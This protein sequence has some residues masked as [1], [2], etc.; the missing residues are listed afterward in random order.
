MTGTA[1]TEA[2]EFNEI[3][4]LDVLEIPTNVRSPVTTTT[5][6]SIGR[7]ARN[8]RPSSTI[9]RSSGAHQPILVG[10][11]SVEKSEHLAE[12]LKKAG[13]TLLDYSDPN[14]L[15][16]VYAAAREGRVTKRFASRRVT[17][18]PIFRL[19]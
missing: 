1:E 3:Y 13:Y 12:M 5:T 8:T 2:D 15:T 11:V 16:D 17:A 6:R 7:P 10:T 18:F 4:G 9:S 14:A 19:K